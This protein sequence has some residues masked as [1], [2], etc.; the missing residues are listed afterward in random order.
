M[1][2]C[3]IW[4]G[5]SLPKISVSFRDVTVIQILIQILIVREK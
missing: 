2:I 3:C 5:W 1:A 4:H